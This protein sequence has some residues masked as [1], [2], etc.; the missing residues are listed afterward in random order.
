MHLMLLK[1]SHYTLSIRKECSSEYAHKL[2][3]CRFNLSFLL[4]S[5]CAYDFLLKGEGWPLISAAS[6]SVTFDMV[7]V[8]LSSIRGLRELR[9]VHSHKKT[10]LQL[11]NQINQRQAISR[12]EA[13]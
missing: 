3:T 9:D 1:E 2:L 6:V 13:K 12:N 10:P 4:R 5:S 11:L 8:L 7:Q